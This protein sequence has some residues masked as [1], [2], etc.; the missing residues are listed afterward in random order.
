MGLR[1]VHRGEIE[2]QIAENEN[3]VGI[4]SPEMRKATD[5]AFG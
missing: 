3:V 4:P 5:F 2:E 1:A